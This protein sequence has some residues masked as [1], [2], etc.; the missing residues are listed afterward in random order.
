MAVLTRDIRT[1]VP[2]LVGGSRIL[3]LESGGA[4]TIY[5][6][7]IHVGTF[8]EILAFSNITSHAGTNPTLDLT[9]QHSPD[10]E[11]WLDG[12]AFTQIT[13]GDTLT[14]KRVTANFGDMIRVKIV[15][16]GTATPTYKWSLYL[17]C[18]G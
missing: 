12:D 5:T 16:G 9:I 8:T 7:T 10:G 2:S 11:H 17:V 3:N 18:K 13:T 14:L 4:G 1:I 6:D 15:I